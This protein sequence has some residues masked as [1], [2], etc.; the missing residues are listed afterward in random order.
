[1]DFREFVDGLSALWAG[2]FLHRWPIAEVPFFAGEI[3]HKVSQIWDS[4]CGGEV[5]GYGSIERLVMATGIWR[6]LPHCLGLLLTDTLLLTEGIAAREVISKIGSA[7]GEL[8]A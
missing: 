4:F 7:L 2:A 5:M 6:G 1:M 3:S 8:V